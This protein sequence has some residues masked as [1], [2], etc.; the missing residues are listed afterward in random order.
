MI[1][2]AAGLA[3][4]SLGQNAPWTAPNVE[5]QD[6]ENE[7]DRILKNGVAKVKSHLRDKWK[8]QWDTY[9]R[10]TGD[11][12]TLVVQG[13]IGPSRLKMYKG[14]EKAVSS[15]TIQIRSEKIGLKDFLSRRR[16]PGIESGACHC[17][18]P[19]QTA[20]HIFIFCPLQ[21]RDELQAQGPLDYS[22][23]TQTN[24]GLKIA[25]TWLMKRGLLAQ[26]SVAVDLLLDA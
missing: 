3:P 21:N 14:L 22:Y 9:R 18:G 19:R 8:A 10:Q 7:K 1:P 4:V 15:L 5:I 2:E 25:A 26:F 17:G 12:Q 13:D 23:Y 24:K 11:S 16:V 20:R 6:L